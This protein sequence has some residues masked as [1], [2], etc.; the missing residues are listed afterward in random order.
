MGDLVIIDFFKA[1]VLVG[2]PVQHKVS[3]DEA[4]VEL[5]KRMSSLSVLKSTRQC[6]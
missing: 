6:P 3:I 5:K 2:P 4:V 1:E